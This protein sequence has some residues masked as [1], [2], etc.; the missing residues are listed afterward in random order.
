MKKLC[1]LVPYRNREEHKKIFVEK[2]TKMLNEFSAIEYYKIAFIEQTS[3]KLFNRG[4]LLNIGFELYEENFDYFVF[5][6]VDM[7]P[8]SVNNYFFSEK[9]TI[10]HLAT[11]ASQFKGGKM[12]YKDY[13][14]GVTLFNTLDFKEVNGFS[15]DYWGWGAEDDDLLARV[16]KKQ[17][18]IFRRV[19]HIDS[20]SHPSNEFDSSGK[21]NSHVNKNRRLFLSRQKNNCFCEEGLNSL[22]YT[23]IEKNILEKIDTIIVEV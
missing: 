11:N 16:R 2:M 15:N 3:E 5:H 12:P 6:D 21:T 9:E 19:T 7:I 1:I 8:R 4:K 23:I 10:V 22:D 14:G 20:L 18:R 17:K 13:F